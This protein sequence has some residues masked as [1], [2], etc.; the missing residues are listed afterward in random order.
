MHRPGDNATEDL[1]TYAVQTRGG[2]VSAEATVTVHVQEPPP[3]LA[4]SPAEL[5]FGAVKAGSSHPGG[6]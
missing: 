5:D 3:V 4:I 2:P 6:R 1:F